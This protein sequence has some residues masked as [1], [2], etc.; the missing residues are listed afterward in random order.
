MAVKVAEQSTNVMLSRVFDEAS[1]SI[2]TTLTNAEVS[3][4]VSALTDSI[5]IGDGAGSTATITDNSGKKSLDVNVTDIAI[6]HANDS[7]RIGDG[8]SNL[9]TVTAANALKVDGSAVN[10]PTK[11]A[12][13]TITGSASTL[14]G[15]VI[16]ST[17]ISGYSTGYLHLTADDVSGVAKVV[18]EGSQDNSNW[19]SIFG[20][21]DNTTPPFTS[22]G[23]YVVEGGFNNGPIEV[24]FPLS[25]RYFRA[26]LGL[27]GSGAT[28]TISGTLFLVAEAQPSAITLA[29]SYL[30]DGGG[31]VVNF[32]Q[33]EAAASFPVVIAS[34]QSPITTTSFK[35]TSDTFT[36]T[37]NGTTVDCTAQPVKQFSLQVTKTGT[38]T[39]WDVRLEG[40]LDGVTFTTILTHTNVSPGDTLTTFNG[41][42]AYPVLYFRARCAGLIIG[43]GT[44][45]IATVLGV[46]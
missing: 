7:I 21:L 2:K 26:R 43:A 13:T 3:L 5:K 45:I 38:V 9:A 41:A 10:Q 11:A 19:L 17:D 46:A 30:L 22:D 1:D 6:S 29:A 33:A 15:L 20:L 12:T 31:S 37:A 32:Q 39:S 28:A 23:A 44:N 34:D 8:G 40:S 42:S 18:Y 36:T 4:S 24:K 35:T 25:Y 16:P 14:N 27:Y